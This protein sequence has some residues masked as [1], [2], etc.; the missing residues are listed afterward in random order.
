MP[1]RD[2]EIVRRYEPPDDFFKKYDLYLS[3]GS[4]LGVDV[5]KRFSE[6]SNVPERW[7]E[8]KVYLSDFATCQI[9]GKEATKD[10]F[11]YYGYDFGKERYLGLCYECSDRL[12]EKEK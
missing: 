2:F 11:I 5:K 10:N 4:L 1:K 8:Q 7:I 9:C 3:K 6:D 12:R